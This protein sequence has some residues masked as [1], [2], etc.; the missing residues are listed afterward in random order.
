MLIGRAFAYQAVSLHAAEVGRCV[1]GCRLVRTGC[2]ASADDSLMMIMLSASL[3][4][5]PGGT[6]LASDILVCP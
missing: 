3:E 1:G 6:L 2:V 4:A 5:A